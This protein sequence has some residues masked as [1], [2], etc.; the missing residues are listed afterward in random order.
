MAPGFTG[1]KA[2]VDEGD[3]FDTI[4]NHGNSALTNWPPVKLG[5]NGRCDVGIKIGEAL[6]VPLGNPH[7]GCKLRATGAAMFKC[8]D[9]C[10]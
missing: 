3:D 6:E 4:V 7:V 8:N 5:G 2:C 9:H 10:F 1:A